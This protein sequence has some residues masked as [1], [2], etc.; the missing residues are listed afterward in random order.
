MSTKQMA[1]SVVV[2]NAYKTRSNCYHDS[3]KLSQVDFVES[4]V[5]PTCSYR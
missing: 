2:G 1:V 4:Q 3:C 5:V